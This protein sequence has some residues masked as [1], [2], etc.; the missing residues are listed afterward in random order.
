[1]APKKKDFTL[2]ELSSIIKICGDNAVTSFSWGDLRISF[3]EK[4]DLATPISLTPHSPQAEA[5]LEEE[6][7]VHDE[8]K[9]RQDQIDQ[10]LIEDPLEAE[11]LIAENELIDEDKPGDDNHGRAEEQTEED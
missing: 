8:L 5:E 10:M 4:K 7:R 3:G 9:V 6:T 1:M 2:E 11:R